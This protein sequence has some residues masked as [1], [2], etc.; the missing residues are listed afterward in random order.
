[1]SNK[2]GMLVCYGK[3]FLTVSSILFT[4]FLKWAYAVTKDSLERAEREVLD[5]DS[6]CECMLNSLPFLDIP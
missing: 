5:K 3:L 4:R 2:F 6:G 1:V